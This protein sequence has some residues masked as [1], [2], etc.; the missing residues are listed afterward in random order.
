MNRPPCR[1]GIRSRYC[2][3]AR[4]VRHVPAPPRTT[5]YDGA[6]GGSSK[7]SSSRTSSIRAPPGSASC[8]R[9]PG[10]PLDRGRPGARWAPEPPRRA[11]G[12]AAARGPRPPR[13]PA[14]RPGRCSRAGTPARRAARSPHRAPR[15]RS[16]HGTTTSP[17][18]RLLAGWASI[19]GLASTLADPARRA[20]LR[21]MSSQT[22]SRMIGS[23]LAIVV[24]T[25]A[26]LRR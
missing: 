8:A 22:H 19:I 24:R 23:A 1:S 13:P 10:P 21:Q 18:R 14:R 4:P 5:P 2:I 9:R 3:P 17:P 26:W 12:A 15:P 16:G 25:A 6:S 20:P 11:R 7:P